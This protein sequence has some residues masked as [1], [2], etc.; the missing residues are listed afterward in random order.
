MNLEL[1]FLGLLSVSSLGFF[2]DEDDLTILDILASVDVEDF[3]KLQDG[4]FL[5]NLEDFFGSIPL[6]SWE[7]SLYVDELMMLC[8]RIWNF[9]QE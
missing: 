5:F 8:D 1:P 4:Y 7:T 3:L 2:V 6:E 9:M